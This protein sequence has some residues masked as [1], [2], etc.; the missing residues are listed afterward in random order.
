LVRRGPQ[1]LTISNSTLIPFIIK[2]V[3]TLDNIPLNNSNKCVTY[4]DLIADPQIGSPKKI[5]LR[6]RA[7]NK[8]LREFY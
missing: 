8:V 1:D 4:F 5:E 3:R 7:E 2:L 6:R